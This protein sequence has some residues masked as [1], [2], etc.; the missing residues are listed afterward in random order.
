MRV[1]V[2]QFPGSNCDQDA[3]YSLREDI[4]VGAD[5]VWYESTSLTGFDAVFVPG[6]FSFGDY[7]RCGAMASRAPV[8]AEVE[9]FADEGRPVIGVCNGFQILCEAGLLPGA[10]LLNESQ[11]FVCKVVHLRAENHV[12]L[13]TRGVDKF[14]EIPVAHGE[15]RFICDDDTLKLLEDTERIAFR[16]VDSKGEMTSESNPNGSTQ[17]IAGVLNVRGNVLGLM[18]HPERATKALL[19]STD[20][21]QILKAL[22]LVEAGL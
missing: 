2:L 7:L 20:G 14:L 21:A 9:R 22:T 3:L 4:A 8:M 16:Y 6:G 5:Y 12:S 15:G 1:A 19:G 17:N 11:K 13:W 18:P 10:L